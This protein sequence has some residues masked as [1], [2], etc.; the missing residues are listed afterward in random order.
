MP[1]R[2]VTQA[3]RDALG[4]ALSHAVSEEEVTKKSE[5]RTALGRLSDAMGGAGTG[6][7]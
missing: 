6:T 3:T 7:I 1:S 4:A 5:V 2:R